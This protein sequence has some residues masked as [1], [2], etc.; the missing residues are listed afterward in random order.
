[1]AKNLRTQLMSEIDKLNTSGFDFKEV[2]PKEIPMFASMDDAG[3]NVEGEKRQP[4]IKETT[5]CFVSIDNVKTNKE[6]CEKIRSVSVSYRN[7][8]KEA[9]SVIA[10]EYGFNVEQQVPIIRTYLSGEF[11]RDISR[12]NL[13]TLVELFVNIGQIRNDLIQIMKDLELQQQNKFEKQL[14]SRFVYYQ[15]IKE[16]FDN[17]KVTMQSVFPMATFLSRRETFFKTGNLGEMTSILPEIRQGRGSWDETIEELSEYHK[18]LIM[19]IPFEK[20]TSLDENMR[21]YEEIKKRISSTYKSNAG[22]KIRMYLTAAVK[23]FIE[24]TTSTKLQVEIKDEV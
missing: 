4:T 14:E 13:F 12:N 10:S 5:D 23:Q 11:E 3:I 2:L 22:K 17:N 15:V 1:M 7:Q 19:F 8:M 6:I 24:A 20:S 16:V 18:A 21:Q 9:I